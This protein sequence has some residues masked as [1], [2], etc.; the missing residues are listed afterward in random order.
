MVMVFCMSVL[1]RRLILVL[2][3]NW[4]KI[5]VKFVPMNESLRYSDRH[6]YMEKVFHQRIKR[7]RCEW[8]TSWGRVFQKALEIPERRQWKS[9]DLKQTVLKSDSY[10]F[11]IGNTSE[12]RQSD[13][14]W[15][16]YLLTTFHLYNFPEWL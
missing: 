3:P 9:F 10:N 12:V 11:I 1:I 5:L 14:P 13:Q 4:K 15:Y 2:F 8:I 16:F 7:L 6:A